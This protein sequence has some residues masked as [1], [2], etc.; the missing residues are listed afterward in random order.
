MRAIN[1]KGAEE[2][3]FRS[4]FSDTLPVSMKNLII[5]MKTLKV[6]I[7]SSISYLNYKLTRHKIM[8]F[9]SKILRVLLNF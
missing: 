7:L 8:G 2:I 9:V 3:L 5:T 6:S 4:Q 1:N